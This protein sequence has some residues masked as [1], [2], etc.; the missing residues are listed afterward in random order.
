VAALFDGEE[1]DTGAHVTT[2]EAEDVQSLLARMAASGIGTAVLEATSHGLHQHRLGCVD[3]DVAAITNITHNEA[4]EYHGTFEAYREAKALLFRALSEGT[5]KQGLT[6]TAVLNAADPSYEYLRRISA[7]RVVTYGVS[8]SAD[9]SA[10]SISHGADGLRFT[11]LTPLGELP[12]VSP[13]VGSYNVAN[14]L[15]AMASAHALGLEPDAMRAGVS[16]MTRIPGRMELVSAGQHFRAIVDFAHTP[17]ALEHALA[18]ARELA[19]ARGRVIA[20]FGCAGLRDPGKRRAMGIV[21]ARSADLV[22]ITAEDPRTE[23]LDAILGAVAAGLREAGA[24]EGRDYQKVADRGEAIRRACEA[25]SAGDVVIVCG[26][27]HETTM[28]F[29]EVEYPW[30]DRDAVRA[31]LAGRSYGDLP[32]AGRGSAA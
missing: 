14:I 28:C 31:A 13:L 1:I 3:F 7:P 8:G 26:K 21:A 2:P 16:C 12:V 6:K 11:A 19:S 24:R 10:R 5:A 30:D 23:D 9:F 22:Y 18:T 32:T 20:V 15:A 27:G 25:A 29:G 4:L 17:N